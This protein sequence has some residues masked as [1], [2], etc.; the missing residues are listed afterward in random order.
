M[1]TELATTTGIDPKLVASLVLNAD[2]KG[3]TKE[4]Q[5]SYYIGLCE[6]LGLDPYTRPFQLIELQGKLTMYATKAATQQLAGRHGI[7]TTVVGREWLKDEG[8]YVVTARASLASGQYTDDMGAV[9]VSG[10]RG[11]AMANAMMKATTKA[12]RRA[13]LALVGLGM[14]D[15]EEMDT[16]AG[17]VRVDV[18]IVEAEDVPTYSQTAEV[19]AADVI[20]EWIAAIE[21][22][23]SDVEMA[24]LIAQ[25]KTLDEPIRNAL[26]TPFNERMQALGLVFKGGRIGKAVAA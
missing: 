10:L 17:A 8:L 5:V 3:M 9:N 4:Q 14:L 2:L 19:D 20:A 7:S 6:R 18:P 12:K 11:E 25:I 15:E 24:K 22:A 1:S 21:G 26:S 13:T 16:V 23:S